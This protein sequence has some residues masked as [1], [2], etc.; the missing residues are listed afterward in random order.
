MYDV[1]VVGAGP[2]GA[3]AAKIAAE[4]GYNTL[5]VE[6]YKMPRYKSCS[7]QLIK[8]TL[9]LVQKFYGESVPQFTMCAPQINKGMIL[10][11]DTGKQYKFEQNGLNVWRSEFDNW[12]ALKAV[13]SG[14]KLRDSTA[15]VSYIDNGDSVTLNLKG[16]TNYSVEA[17][18]VV[19]CEGVIGSLKKQIVGYS[20][21]YITTFQTYNIGTVG[22]DHSYFYAF[23]QPE[24]SEY[25]A[26]MNVKDDQIV[27]GV[28]VVD[29][30]KIDYYYNKFI[31]Y[32]VDS[33]ALKIDRQI[34]VDKWLMP[35][36]DPAAKST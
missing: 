20:G 17:R 10:T 5:L 28:C 15:A 35:S 23:L 9:D 29:P 13:A 33:H 25:D 12:L 32:M 34:K 1:V 2:S 7:G 6:K 3:T 8:K 24:L 19:D 4:M 27:L 21:D 22:L 30:E 18:Y 31:N 14:A 16:Q 11:E 26:W 36:F